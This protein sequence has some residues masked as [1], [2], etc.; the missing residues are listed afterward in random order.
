MAAVAPLQQAQGQAKQQPQRQQQHHGSGSGS[1]S[2]DALLLEGAS[3]ALQA[4]VRR[5]REALAE[6]ERQIERKSEEAAQMAEV[7]AALQR[8]NEEL[9]QGKD[10]EAVADLQRWVGGALGRVGQ[11]SL[12][13][14]L[15]SWWGGAFGRAAP[16]CPEGTAL[17][18]LMAALP[19]PTLC[20]GLA[21]PGPCLQG[22]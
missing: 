9:A 10:G 20:L 4:V 15:A 13:V 12:C 16:H 3:P 22:V 18:C 5:L 11:G 17:D 1:A 2:E 8:K 6:R 14:C 21:S 7:T 19:T